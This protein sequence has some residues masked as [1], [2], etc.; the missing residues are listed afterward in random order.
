MDPDF[1]LKVG[2]ALQPATGG[3]GVG[4]DL[5]S[6]V[7]VHETQAITARQF[8]RARDQVTN[9]I[10]AVNTD[11]TVVSASDATSI[12]RYQQREGWVQTAQ[13]VNPQS[14]EIVLRS[15]LAETKDEIVSETISVLP[16]YPGATP[17]RDFDVGDWI[18]REVPSYGNPYTEAVRVL[19]ISFSID[20]TGAETCELTVFTYRQWLQQQLLYLVNKFGGQFVNALGTT[21]VTSIGGTQSVPIVTAPQLGGLSD[22]TLGT[23]HQDPLV[24]NANADMWQNASNIGPTGSAIGLAVGPS[25]AS[26]AALAPAAGQTFVQD[27]GATW[28]V[29]SAFQGL[30]AGTS[31]TSP[32]IIVPLIIFEGAAN[33]QLGFLIAT[34]LSGA[35]GAGLLLTAVSADGSVS[36]HARFGTVMLTGTV[37]AWTTTNTII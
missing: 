9:S 24:Y 14:M 7:F 37:W 25:G 16:S 34:G 35:A 31:E 36:A 33:E 2:L 22:V 29:L 30:S 27:G 21:P 6:T 8:V 32:A 13:A 11:G 18:S 19:G 10:G 4:R 20:S 23:D 5:T 12:A 26:K 28:T 15:S 17:L 1:V 3:I